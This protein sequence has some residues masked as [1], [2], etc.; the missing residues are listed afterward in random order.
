MRRYIDAVIFDLDGVITDTAEYHFRA[1]KQL[2][3][4]E[5]IPFTR[6]DNEQLR[7]VSRRRSLELILQ[8]RK[9][10][11][12]QAEALMERKNRMYLN[13]VRQ[14]SADDLLPGVSALLDDLQTN[15]VK[16]AVASASRNAQEVIDRLGI[17]NKLDYV[18]D[19]SV[20]QRTKP[21][22]DLFLH[23]ARKLGVS[24]TRC[25]VVEDA[26]SGVQAARDAGMVVVGIGPQERV[27]EADLVLADLSGVTYQTLARAATWRVSESDFSPERMHMYETVFT[28]GNGYLGT[29]GTL[30]ERYP[31]DRQATLIH[32]IWDDAPVVFTELANVPDWTAFDL[33]VEGEQFRHDRGII[34]DYSR[35]LD[36]R[37]GVLQRSLVWRSAADAP[38]IRMIFERFPSFDD[39][40]IQLLR[41][42]L[43][44]LDQPIDLEGR[45]MLDAQVENEGLRHIEILRQS[46][47][48]EQADLLVHTRH[49]HKQ[50][51]M[52]M[53][54]IFSGAEVERLACNCRGCPGIGFKAHLEP[55]EVLTIE[56]Y[57]AVYTSREEKHPLERAKQKLDEVLPLG[58]EHLYQKNAIKWRDFWRVSD[59]EIE[60]DEEAQIAVRHA[61]FQLRIAASETDEYVS[62]GAKTLSGFAYRGH[63]FWDNEIFVLPFFIY[64]HPHLARNL[65]MYRWHTLSGARRNAAKNGYNGAQFAWES[66]ETGEEV[67]PKWVPSAEN[68]RELIRIWT[69]D[70]EIHI[71]A[72]IAYALYQYWQATGDDEFW[73]NYGLPI[74]LETALFWESRVEPENGRFAIRDVIGP[75][76]YHDHVDNNAFTN[77][78]V[79]WHLQTALD[80]IAW[81]KEQDQQLASRVCARL[82]INHGRMERWQKIIDNIIIL[83]DKESGLFEQFEG[84]FSLPEV[85]WEAYKDRTLSMQVLLGIEG[86]NQ[87]QVLKQADVILLLCLLREQFDRQTWQVNWDYY[88]PRTDHEYGSSLSPA[89]HAWAACEMGN[90]DLAYEHFMRAARA[91]LDD[92]RGNAGEGIHAA[93]AGGLWQAIVF[94]FAGVR[95]T[96]QGPMASP[97]LPA[98]WRRL[99]FN[100]VYRGKHYPFDIVQKEPPVS[101]REASTGGGELPSKT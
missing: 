39:P 5:G 62:I 58:Y 88:N 18:A 63:V 37:T 66:A 77:V 57:V 7:G 67:T 35:Y 85:D 87:H 68:P 56:K 84:F 61:L 23:V 29:R 16:I 100:L 9:I 99:K 8:G 96:H 13:L 69:G 72:D 40:H 52:S 80:A 50:V 19:G 36:L 34:E 98:H 48:I 59:I 46:S 83:Q 6:Q 14:I 79:R 30:E 92:I 64:N 26:A 49:T 3:D 22:P 24:P 78:M 86:A 28:Q 90:P 2:A 25:L 74:L 45:G 12:A 43:I 47:S 93:S 55:D 60:G 27:G 44:P 17:R 76:E 91:D 11:E 1:W 70:I 94:G 81:L 53:G 20:V 75:D 33:W 89:I 51:G 82:D 4:E 71:N 21:A 101:S 97:R 10:S 41:I 42:R 54:M 15:G 31:G 73:V 38:K 32:G 95:F 65:L